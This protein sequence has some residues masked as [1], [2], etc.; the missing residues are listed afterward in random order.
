M[1]ETYSVSLKMSLEYNVTRDIPL[2]NGHL[3][4]SQR[5][6]MKN[7]SILAMFILRLIHGVSGA[8][9]WGFP[10]LRGDDVSS[11]EAHHKWLI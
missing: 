5:F 3:E 4:N 6:H 2:V 11:N 8:T 10:N 9:G 1:T 7:G